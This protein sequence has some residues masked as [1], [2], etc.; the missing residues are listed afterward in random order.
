MVNRCTTTDLDKERLIQTE[1]CKHTRNVKTS[2]NVGNVKLKRSFKTVLENPYL[3][4]ITVYRDLNY[5]I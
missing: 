4:Q 5:D 2:S 1:F 3:V